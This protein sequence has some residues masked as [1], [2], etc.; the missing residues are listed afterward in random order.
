MKSAGRVLQDH[1]LRVIIVDDERWLAIANMH[2]GLSKIFENT[3][4]SA[5]PGAQGVWVQAL[6]RLPHQV[7][8]DALYF[9]SVSRATLLPLKLCLPDNIDDALDIRKKPVSN[10]H[11]EPPDWD[12][13]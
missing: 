10:G 3:Q 9:G 1:G 4:W 2:R 11:S 5:R 8:K 13:F 7:S 12:R 6:R